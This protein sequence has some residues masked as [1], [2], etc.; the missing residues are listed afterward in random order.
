MGPIRRRTGSR[1]KDKEVV[2]PA[3]AVAT[4]AESAERNAAVRQRKHLAIAASFSDEVSQD[5]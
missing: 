4:F 3:A 5:R 1:S 2:N